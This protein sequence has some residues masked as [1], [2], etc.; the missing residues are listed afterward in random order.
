MKKIVI[1]DNSKAVKEK[2]EESL[3]EDGYSVVGY[4]NSGLDAIKIIEDTNPDL[5]VSDFVLTHMDGLSVLEH[6]K[7]HENA[8]IFIM[9]SA[10]THDTVVQESINLGASY[11][12]AK[13]C[14]IDD[15]S[16]RIMLFCESERV[17]RTSEIECSAFIEEDTERISNR[18]EELK[19]KKVHKRIL[20]ILVEL[21][22]KSS[23]KGFD[24]LATGL[25]IIYNNPASR[26]RITDEV[27]PKI[28]EK[29][30]VKTHNI[31]RPIR[32]M[33]KD[34]WEHI[35]QNVLERIFKNSTIEGVPTCSKLMSD[36][37]NVLDMED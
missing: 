12:I 6:F 15:L 17:S 7:E 16:K 32:Y 8:P 31:E 4:S 27:Y 13:P 3:S 10:V 28:A 2:I 11:F 21:G 37:L 30:G 1:L 26:T 19:T 34:R 20:N 24:Y 14:S 33:I 18:R 22:F 36:I 25:E 29:Y 23:V 9:F 5:V 35:D